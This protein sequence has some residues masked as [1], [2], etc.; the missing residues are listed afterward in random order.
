[1]A[2][3]TLA[4]RDALSQACAGLVRRARRARGMTQDQLAERVGVLR[5]NVVRLES[6]RTLPTLVLLLRVAL[7][8][9]VELRALV[10]D[11]ASIVA[12]RVVTD[13]PRSRTS[14]YFALGLVLDPIPPPPARGD[15]QR[16]TREPSPRARATRPS[17]TRNT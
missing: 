6:G 9:E 8:L 14:P 12:P 5:P 11:V 1:M 10:P 2:E 17:S 15:R 16:C 3:T 13:G 7:V 4:H